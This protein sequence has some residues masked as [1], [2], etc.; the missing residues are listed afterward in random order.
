MLISKAT[1]NIIIRYAPPTDTARAPSPA[2][3]AALPAE[4][5]KMVKMHQEFEDAQEE[6]MRL[7]K[8]A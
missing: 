2:K 1:N 8:R 6:Y 5:A 4:L 3:L 7:M